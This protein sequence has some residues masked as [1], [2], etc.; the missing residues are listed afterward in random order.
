MIMH[1]T[2]EEWHR[3]V[4][5][6]TQVRH[7]MMTTCITTEVFIHLK[8]KSSPVVMRKTRGIIEL[9]RPRQMAVAHIK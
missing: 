7:Q 2:C 1:F 5:R 6:E 8:T 4:V 3:Y 9:Q